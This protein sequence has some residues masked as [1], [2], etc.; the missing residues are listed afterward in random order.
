MLVDS[1]RVV[2]R[3]WHLWARE[4]GLDPDAFLAIAHGRRTSETLRL[5]AP[6]LDWRVEVAALDR[7]EE[8]ETD[9]LTAAPAAADLLGRLPPTAWAVVTSGSCAVARLRLD[10]ARLP[11]PRILIT[12]NDVERGKPDPQGYR[13][14]AARLD[15]APDDC[16]VVEDAPPGVAAAQAAGMRVVA[17]LT[18]HAADRL[19]AADARIAGLDALG[20]VTRHGALQLELE[21][22]AGPPAGRH[23]PQP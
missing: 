17:V 19:H 16:V 15:V 23:T 22:V 3:V 2:E 7:M 18:T 10:A 5:L 21:T 11:I 12:G 8:S 4:H 1:R 9:G 6:A 14:A 13:L 20:V